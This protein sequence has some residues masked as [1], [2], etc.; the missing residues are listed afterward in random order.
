MRGV[1]A[2]REVRIQRHGHS[3]IAEGRHL[4]RGYQA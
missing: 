3:D 1:D 4:S 2:V